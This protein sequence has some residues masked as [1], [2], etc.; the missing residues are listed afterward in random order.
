MPQND[1]GLIY[2]SIKQKTED[3]KPFS[4]NKVVD[5]KENLKYVKWLTIPLMVFLIFFV[6]GNQH[7]IT[8]SS[9]RI[10]DYNTKYIPPA[11][12]SFKIENV[13]LDVKQHDDFHLKL[14]EIKC[15]L[16]FPL[17]LQTLKV[18]LH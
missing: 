10:L 7:I 11:P 1:N 12:F 4:F 13:R 17:K 9:A 16:K 6:S 15:L 3:I 14:S 18:H 5:F 2:A 8:E